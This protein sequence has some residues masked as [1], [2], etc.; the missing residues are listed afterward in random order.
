MQITVK[1]ICQKQLM[2]RNS[3]KESKGRLIVGK[4]VGVGTIDHFQKCNSVD[5]C[6]LLEQDAS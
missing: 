6:R 2:Y 5:A 3:I 4:F 1:K